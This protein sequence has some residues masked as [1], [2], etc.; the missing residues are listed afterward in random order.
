MAE[1]E[2][3]LVAKVRCEVCRFE[4]LGFFPEATDQQA[5]ECDCCG[6]QRSEVLELLGPERVLG[7]AIEVKR[8]NAKR[9]GREPFGD[10][11]DADED[12]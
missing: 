5:L 2:Y 12:T 1:I 4:W 8:A 6:I 3:Y 9:E 10:E 7:A 11:F